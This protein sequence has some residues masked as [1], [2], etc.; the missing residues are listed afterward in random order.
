[1]RLTEPVRETGNYH[2]PDNGITIIRRPERGRAVV[3]KHTPYGGEHDHYDKPGLIIY[4]NHVP[5]LPDMG[6]TGYGAPMH[7]SSYKNTL[8][9]NV[10]CVEGFNQ[11]LVNPQTLNFTET[12]DYA[13]VTVEI[14]LREPRPTSRASTA[15]SGMPMPTVISSTGERWCCMSTW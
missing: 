2:D 7:Y 3:P 1:L 6:A 10:L 5:I 13:E 4:D 9:H 14:D 8:T 11:P 12:D 15:W